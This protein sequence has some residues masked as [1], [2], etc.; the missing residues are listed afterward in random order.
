MR[1]F[2]FYKQSGLS[3]IEVIIV[4]TLI[5]IVLVIATT[6]LF[7]P[8]RKAEL[9]RVSADITSILREAQDKAINTDAQGD[10]AT[11]EFGVHFETDKF[12]LFKG[13]NFVSGDQD[14]FVVNVG[15]SLQLTPNLTCPSPPGNC[16]NIVFQKISGEVASYDQ[17]NNSVCINDTATNKSTLISV[18]AV[19]VI[20]VQE[21]C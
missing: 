17:S 19:G 5:S 14:N 13:I 12:I 11:D 2:F 3:L 9:G 18:N 6:N 20:N 4:I 10:A 21:T 15:K 8:T 1:K 16:N 7:S